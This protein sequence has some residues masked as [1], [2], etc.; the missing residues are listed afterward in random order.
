MI[1]FQFSSWNLKV[2]R[3][4]FVAFISIKKPFGMS[5]YSFKSV[6]CIFFERKKISGSSSNS[7]KWAMVAEK[8]YTQSLGFISSFNL[9]TLLSHSKAV[10]FLW[11]FW[12]ILNF[13]MM[14][15]IFL[16]FLELRHISFA[17]STFTFLLVQLKPNLT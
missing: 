1:T 10:F 7:A 13:F 2:N 11:V 16:F 14:S 17:S 9:L 3:D 8:H 12:M 5:S 6:K 4:I 15:T